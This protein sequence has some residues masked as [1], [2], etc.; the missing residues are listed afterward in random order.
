MGVK[1]VG[2]GQRSGIVLQ[3]QPPLGTVWSMEVPHIEQKVRSLFPHI[4][5]FLIWAVPRREHELRWEYSLT[6][7]LLERVS[8]VSHHQPKVPE[9][10]KLSPL[11]WREHKDSISHH[12]LHPI[13][14]IFLWWNWPRGILALKFVWNW[15][16][17]TSTSQ[18][19]LWLA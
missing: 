14:Q 15:P 16:H 5:R 10:V 13:L 3:S 1:E 4:N 17:V 9:T 19:R 18:D 12:L 8:I 7:K 6:E 11:S 2:V